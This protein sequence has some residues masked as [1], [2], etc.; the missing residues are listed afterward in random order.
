MPIEEVDLR[1]NDVGLGALRESSLLALFASA[2]AHALTSGTGHTLRDVTD[3]AGAQLYPGYYW[4]HL[5]VPPSQPIERFRVWDRV[6]VG[7]DVRRYGKIILDSTYVLG[8]PGSLDHSPERWDLTASPSMRASSMWTVDGVS[9]QPQVATPKEGALATLARLDGPPE[10]M[11]RLRDARS[12]GTLGREARPFMTKAPVR[13]E[14]RNGRD[15]APGHN[16]MFAT[17]VEI[18]S[19]AEETLLREG[20]WPPLPDRLVAARRPV[21]REVLFLQNAGAGDS[22]LADARA[23]LLGCEP[24]LHGADREQVS[25]AVVE[26]TGELYD[27]NTRALLTVWRAR[28][29]VVVPR[30]AATLLTDAQRFIQA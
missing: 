7:V 23:S 22:V 5:R 27:E 21:E 6:A 14:V 20:A 29:L 4:L 9:G 18:M 1:L 12:R 15:V 13:F 26:I 25:A 8:A 30:S 2:Q 28:Q 19:L 11:N 3:A 10:S 16:L 17:Y 24:A